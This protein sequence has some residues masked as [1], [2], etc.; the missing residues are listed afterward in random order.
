M[1]FWEIC[2]PS[3]HTA[4][5]RVNS[6]KGSSVGAKIVGLA[7]QTVKQFS[8]SGRVS[9]PVSLLAGASQGKQGRD[10]FKEQAG[11]PVLQG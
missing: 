9:V 5:V 1:R 6:P 11:N 3:V 2:I 4:A 10:P 8:R 7:K